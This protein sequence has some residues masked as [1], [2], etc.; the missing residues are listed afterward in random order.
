MRATNAR[1]WSSKALRLGLWSLL[2]ALAASRSSTKVIL[3]LSLL[4]PGVKT[5]HFGGCSSMSTPQ[6][7]EPP[8]SLFPYLSTLSGKP[9]WVYAAGA[10]Q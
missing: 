2:L 6:K 8:R 5:A 4:A 3:S 9:L 1:A 7:M 10:G